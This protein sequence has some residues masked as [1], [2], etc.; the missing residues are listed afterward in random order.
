M[1]PDTLE[2]VEETVDRIEKYLYDNQENFEIESVYSYYESTHAQSTIILTEDDSASKDVMMIKKEIE[3]GLPKI[4]T[5]SPSFE[6]NDQTG[7]EQ[8]RLYVIGESSELLEEL[9]DEVIRRLEMTDGIADARSEA[10]AGSEEVQLVI[11]RERA[12]NY[13]LSSQQIAGMVSNSMRGMNL[14]RVRDLNGEVDVVLAFRDADRRSIDDLMSLPVN[15]SGDQT[16]KLA[17]LADFE[18]NRGP[19]TIQRQDRQTSLGITVNLD[20]ITPDEA[21]TSIAGVLDQINYPTGYGWSYGRSFQEDQEAMDEMI[22]NMLLAM[23]LIYLVMASLFESVLFPSS[24]ITSI[25][26]GIIGVFWFFFLTGTTFSFMA[27]IGILILMG[28]VV[29]NGIVL[30]DHVTQLRQEGLSREQAIIKGGKDRMRPIL[31]TAGTTILGLLPL[32]FGT[33]QIGG[34]G[35]SYF[36]M[37][38]AIVGGLA[39]STIITL[40]ILPSIY[41]ILDDIKRWG[42][43]VLRAAKI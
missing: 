31:M 10:E 24:I 1:T 6:Y 28:I 41:I 32:C 25:F 22:I 12:R 20:G 7:G 11:D 3:E 33:T 27:M 34:D 40:V 19:R 38:R 21:Q 5:G 36:P 43:R 4:S 23:V 2:R 15:V 17:S 8:M 37:A 9:S 39:F 18:L 14:R 42:Q 30:I 29:N 26:Y 13:G 16:V 35:P